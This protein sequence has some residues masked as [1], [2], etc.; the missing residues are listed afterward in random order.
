[1]PIISPSHTRQQKRIEL[2]GD[3]KA[4]LLYVCIICMLTGEGI[5]ERSVMMVQRLKEISDFVRKTFLV[6]FISIM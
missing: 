5:Q 2:M 6:K 1:M 3:S 4:C